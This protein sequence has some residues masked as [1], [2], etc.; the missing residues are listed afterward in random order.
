MPT[1]KIAPGD[2]VVL[3]SGGPMMTVVTEAES[4]EGSICRCIWF[5]DDKKFL[6]GE[7]HTF[8]LD[9]RARGRKDGR[10]GKN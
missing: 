10:P 6:I 9:K 8:L 2:V 1:D 3:R 7:F 5:Q 4:G